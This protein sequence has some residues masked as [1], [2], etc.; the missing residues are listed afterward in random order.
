MSERTRRPQSYV[1]VGWADGR[2]VH[3]HRERDRR[4]G[5]CVRKI[6]RSLDSDLRLLIDDVC[7][8]ADALLGL[9]AELIHLLLGDADLGKLVLGS[10]LLALDDGLLERD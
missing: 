3:H 9:G 4:V 8:L 5:D 1:L 10:P 2:W 7:Q 6:F